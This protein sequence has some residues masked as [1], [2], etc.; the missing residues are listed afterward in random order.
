MARPGPAVVPD[1]EAPLDAAAA[2]DPLG[3]SAPGDY[4]AT[5]RAWVE[6]IMGMPISIHVRGA[7]ARSPEVADAV[8]GV[9]DE[10]R[11]VDATF[12]TYRED[13][14]VSRLQRGELTLADAD[15]AMREVE[16]LCRTAAE[17]TQGWFDAWNAVPGRPGVYDPTGLVKTWGVARAA[18][19]LRA[20]AQATGLGYAVGAGGDV[21]VRA[22]AGGEPWLIGIEDPRARSVVLATVP[23]ADGGIATSGIA[24]R[25]THIV[26]PFSG[27]RVTDVLS[28][29]VV[30][31]SLLWAD[32]FATAAVAMGPAAVGWTS[33]LPDTSGLLVLA[34]GTI[35]RWGDET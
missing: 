35:H 7:D 14:Q 10:L 33:T 1:G 4:R 22:A 21:L 6:Q 25:G 24:V 9:F 2:H 12:S 23:V 13:S 29:T 16:R 27:D 32:V 31:P 20:L 19:P 11:W 17:R 26:D 34:D 28:A 5:H 3:A 30:G 18:K 8:A 15:P